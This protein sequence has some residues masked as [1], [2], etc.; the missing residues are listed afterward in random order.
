MKRETSCFQKKRKISFI[1]NAL[2]ELSIYG[3]LANLTVSSCAKTET[4]EI[5]VEP[6]QF[7][8]CGKDKSNEVK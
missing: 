1:V 6:T 4:G 7:S 2:P 5:F 3:M 8:L